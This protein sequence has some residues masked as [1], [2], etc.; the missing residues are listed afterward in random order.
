MRI[1]LAIL[2]FLTIYARE[3]KREYLVEGSDIN[4]SVITKDTKNDIKLFS[5]P[6]NRYQKRVSVLNILKI[7]QQN[8]YKDFK[9]PRFG[10]ITF[11]RASHI[12]TTKLK[13]KIKNYFLNHY[14]DMVINNV[15]VTPRGYIE[16]M[17]KEYILKMQPKSFLKSSGIC[18]V[19]LP[20]KR[21]LFFDYY[22]DGGLKVY[23]SNKIIKKGQSI[24]FRNIK[25]VFVRFDR[26]F[27]KPVL[28]INSLQAKHN[29]PKNRV[30]TLRDVESL[31]LVHKRDTVN[32][33]YNKNGIEIDFSAKSLQNGKLGDIITVVNSKKKRLRVKVIG[34]NLVKMTE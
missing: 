27:A 1:F 21:M 12:D 34:K 22:V 31:D 10:Y 3:L 11:K 16:K 28:E 18:S 13:E 24:D 6:K 25:A 19:K 5:I 33:I 14:P 17:P 15:T 7:L 23:K 2:I 30:I 20:S 26:F 32:V 4:L 8:G 29:I 9:K